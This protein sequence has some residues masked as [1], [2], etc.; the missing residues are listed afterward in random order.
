MTDTISIELQAG[1]VAFL[2]AHAGLSALIDGR[3]YDQPP[4]GNRLVYPYVRIG[5]IEPR[6][7]HADGATSER[8]TFS[9]EAHTRQKSGGR[10]PVS[11]I[12]GQVKAALDGHTVDLATHSMVSL[13]WVTQTIN[14]ISD[15]NG[16]VAISVFSSVIDE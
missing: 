13:N 3:V 8:V 15:R 9:I 2:R 7:L 16:Y 14:Q 1:L 10:I 5:A 4:V 6:P 11:K 12:A